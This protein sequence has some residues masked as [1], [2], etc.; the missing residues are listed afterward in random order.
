M[1]RS[2]AFRRYQLT[3][4][5]PA[6]HG[7]THESIK[8]TLSEFPSLTYWAMCDE[9]GQEGTPHTHVYVVFD[10]SVMWKTMQKRFHGAHIEPAMGSHQDN[11]TYLR[12]EGNHSEK[13]DTNLPD[14]FEASSDTLPP[15]RHAAKKETEAIYEMIKQ[16][17]ADYEILEAYPNAMIKLDKIERARQTVQAERWKNEFRHLI[18]TYL[19]GKTGV[20]KTRKIM[21]LYG[22][23]NVYRVTNYKHPFDTYKNQE[24]IVFEEFRSSLPIS[25]MLIYLDGYPAVLPCRFVDKF[26]SF[27]TVFVISNIPIEKQYPQDHIECPETWNAFYRRF[28]KIAEM[29][30][31]GT[32]NEKI[33]NIK[34][35][36]NV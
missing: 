17:A 9:I 8:Q 30:P 11:Y 35:K 18:V 10:N 5:N 1:P 31:D 14:T 19:S 2:T 24:V 34:E 25:E 33:I 6:E 28:H 16:G 26:A 23:S 27:S 3:I 4:E 12:K 36:D 15:D 13:H 7:F 20:G 22:Y 29:L 21:E 32:T